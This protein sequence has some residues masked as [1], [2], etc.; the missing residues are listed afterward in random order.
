VRNSGAVPRRASAKPPLSAGFVAV[1]VFK[2]LKAAAFLLVG[3]VALRI[4]RL[5]SHSEPMHLA[6]LL[7]IRTERESVRRLSDLLSHVTPGQVEAAGAASLL[8]ALVFLAEGT[9]LAMRIWWATYFTI[10]LT[11]LGLPI[12]IAEIVARPGRVRGYALLAINAAILLYV[13]TRRNEF[14]R[15]QS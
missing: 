10:T 14:R 2:Y 9:L 13:W 1:I 7:Q 6:R 15:G 4:A 5:P 8:I 12:E 11:A 3:I